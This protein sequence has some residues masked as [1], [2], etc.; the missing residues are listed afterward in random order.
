MGPF[1]ARFHL[2]NC[3]RERTHEK[4]FF[5]NAKLGEGIRFADKLDDHRCTATWLIE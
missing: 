1:G 2:S 4:S 3:A 5:G